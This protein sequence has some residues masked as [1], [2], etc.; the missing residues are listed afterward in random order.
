MTQVA[1][2]R[3]I[4][5]SVDTAITAERARQ[6]NVRNDASGF[7]PVRELK[8]LSNYEGGLRKLRVFSR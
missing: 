2:R 7:G 6:A 8:E 4:K 3:M 5:E 1:I